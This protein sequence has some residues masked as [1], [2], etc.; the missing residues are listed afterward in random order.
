MIPTYEQIEDQSEKEGRKLFGEALTKHEHA[1][2][3]GI[4]MA[5]WAISQIKELGSNLDEYTEEEKK[6]CGN[7]MYGG[8]RHDA[9]CDQLIHAGYTED[10]VV[11]VSVGI[12]K[13]IESERFA[14]LHYKVKM[15]ENEAE[16]E[17]L[18]EHIKNIRGEQE[19]LME[20]ATRTK[21]ILENKVSVCESK[22]SILQEAAYR[23]LRHVN[24]VE[25][26]PKESK[27]VFLKYNRHA[28]MEY[29]RIL[30]KGDKSAEV[31]NATQG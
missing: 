1:T 14:S 26:N 5:K 30:A 27:E 7:Q 10:E 25:E 28:L 31:S 4:A 9:I 24:F 19:I 17:R 21:I 2:K 16:I 23:L 11:L 29:K 18:N 8:K 22:F 13:G 6:A 3:V 20:K 12:W 15:L